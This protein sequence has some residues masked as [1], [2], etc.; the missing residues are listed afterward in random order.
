MAASKLRVRKGAARRPRAQEAP[1]RPTTKTLP[2]QIRSH[3]APPR[4]GWGLRSGLRQHQDTAVDSLLRLLREPLASLLA[5]LV[6]GIALALPLGLFLLL[7][8]LE[9]ASG[10]L[11]ASA[12]ISLFLENGLPETEALA[13]RDDLLS[14]PDVADVNY[15]S[16]QEA[17]AEFQTRA[18]FGEALQGL[19]ENPLPG[20][21]LL[22]PAA[23]D[24]AAL[25][26]LLR[27]L[28]GLQGVDQAQLDLQWLRRLRALV[29]LAGRLTLGLAVLLGL[30]V[31]L[32]IGNTVRAGLEGRRAEILV[33]KLVGGTDAYVARPFLYTGLWYG[34]GGGLLVQGGRFALRG[35][36]DALTALYGSPFRLGWLPPS[37]VLLVALGGGLL[38]WLGA[39]LSVRRH[40]RAIEP[41]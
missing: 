15:I 24:D 23:L 11:D 20:V 28:E 7:H 25:Q 22:Q 30:G 5:W 10:G 13:L 4:R 37:T 17:L 41:R 9:R 29:D 31:L 38:G 14:R 32:V 27:D 8:N 21:L 34:C 3:A 39:W 12:G 18:G 36:V 33:L 2:K 16:P 19:E 26:S 1:K 6:I 40:L 35:A